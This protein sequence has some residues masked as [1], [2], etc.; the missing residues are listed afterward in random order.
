MSGITKK[1]NGVLTWSQENILLAP[2]AKGV[3]VLRNL[4]TQNGI[5]YI[6]Y[7]SDMK[8]TLQEKWDSDAMPEAEWFDWYQVESEQDGK[9]IASQ[10]AEKFVPRYNAA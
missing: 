6:E 4:P 9:R 10:W 7:T 8:K 1:S 3:C 2:S 5:I